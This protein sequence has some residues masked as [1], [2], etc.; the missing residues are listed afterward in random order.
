MKKLFALF[1]LSFTIIVSAQEKITEG[2]VI[3]NQKMTTDNEQLKAQLETMGDIKTRTYFKYKKSRSELSNPMS[4][5]VITISDVE[6]METLMLMD[7]PM[8]GKK[9]MLQK[10]DGTDE[11][12]KGVEVVEGKETKTILGY[13]CKQFTVI[14]NKD[15]LDMKM[16]MFTTEDILAESQQTA[17]LGEKI[18]GFP[19]YMT[20]TM[21]QMGSNM[22]IITEVVEIKNDTV[23]DDMFNMTPPEGYEKMTGQ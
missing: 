19:M 4:G 18:K 14:M 23:S 11:S 17:M 13:I 1:L 7:S 9:Y 12:L 22:T 3:S 6:T 8:L 2:I 5:D 21:N 16:E 15:G 20:I 10:T